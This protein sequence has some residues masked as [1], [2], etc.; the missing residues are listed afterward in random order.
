M[1]EIPRKDCLP[2][3][4]ESCQKRITEH[5][6]GEAVAAVDETEH[7]TDVDETEHTTDVDE[8][9]YSPSDDEMTGILFVQL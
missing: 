9:R 5:W 6:W 2:V 3:V 7:T 4:C 8:T 1:G